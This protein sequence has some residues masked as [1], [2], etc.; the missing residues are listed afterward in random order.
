M[1]CRG[2]FRP[3]FF[4]L[5]SKRLKPFCVPLRFRGR[6]RVGQVV[7]RPGSHGRIYPQRLSSDSPGKCI[8]AISHS[9]PGSRLPNILIQPNER[10]F[11]RESRFSRGRIIYTCGI[12]L[13]TLGSGRERLTFTCLFVRIVAGI[14]ILQSLQAKIIFLSRMSTL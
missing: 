9:P 1:C 3:R 12:R 7:C 11:G 13:L 4:G 5:G 10:F 8:P 2:N 6:T 14:A